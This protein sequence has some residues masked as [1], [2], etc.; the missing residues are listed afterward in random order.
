MKQKEMQEV[1]I[2]PGSI[3]GCVHLSLFPQVITF[4]LKLLYY[5]LDVSTLKMETEKSRGF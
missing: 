4:R 5:L 1:F 2:C 3:K